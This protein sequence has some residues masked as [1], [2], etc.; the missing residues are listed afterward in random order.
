M[1]LS[2]SSLVISKN[3]S[4][5]NNSL[6]VRTKSSSAKASVKYNNYL[7]VTIPGTFTINA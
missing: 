7:V 4:R 5:P 1:P 2:E 3:I 6:T